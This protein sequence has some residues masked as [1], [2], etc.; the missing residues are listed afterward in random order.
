MSKEGDRMDMFSLKGIRSCMR[1]CLWTFTSTLPD[2]ALFLP[3]PAAELMDPVE[4]GEDCCHAG[5][6]THFSFLGSGSLECH[7]S[8]TISW[9]VLPECNIGLG[10]RFLI[11]SLYHS[12]ILCMF[13]EQ[14]IHNVK[15]SFK[16]AAR[17][18]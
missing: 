13:T 5:N 10:C 9:A 18:S 12:V 3:T 7:F 1:E 16:I 17:D 11:S 6:I 15:S 8:S 4:A 2:T 14:Y